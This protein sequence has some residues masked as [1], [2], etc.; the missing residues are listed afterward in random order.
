MPLPFIALAP[1]LITWGTRALATY[2]LARL[3][4]DNS[5]ED[6]RRMVLDWVV[7]HAAE[8]AG[9]ELD[10]DDPL[11][12]A[13][14]AGAVSQKTGVTLRSLKDRVMIQEDLDTHA[15]ALISNKS[16]YMIHSVSN[17]AVLRA[18]L[19]RVATAV[20][21]DK[22]GLP[23]GVLP[24]DGE[25]I[26]PALIK[27]RLLSWAKA[28]LMQ[29]ITGQVGVSVA[30]IAAIGDLESLA[31]EL[32]GRLLAMGSDFEVSGNKMAV[33]VAS[34]LIR[35]AITDYQRVADG[36]SKHTRRQ[37]QLRRAQ[38]TFRAKWGSRM[39]YVP[40]P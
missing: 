11:S 33:A 25:E 23:V 18:D 13:S 31:G 32:N 26:N 7:D 15:A 9:L 30:E 4:S 21:T 2:G 3:F 36:S 8:R 38:A 16:G 40:V 29:N 12:D 20:L 28:E 39:T 5:I 1:L 27:E 10:R 19:Q 22:L 34:K 14:L 24:G 6:L 17:V 35:R 37:E